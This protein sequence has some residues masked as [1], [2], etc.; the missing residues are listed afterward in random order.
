MTRLISLAV[1]TH[2]SITNCFYSCR[3]WINKCIKTNQTDHMTPNDD[4]DYQDELQSSSSKTSNDVV[5]S[6]FYLGSLNRL[7]EVIR[8]TLIY[9]FSHSVILENNSF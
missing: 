4:P 6:S 8:K 9:F 5:S 1:F 3:N 2:F 7:Q